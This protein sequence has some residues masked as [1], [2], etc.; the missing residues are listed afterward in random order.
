MKSADKKLML[1]VGR[2]KEMMRPALLL[3]LLLSL[4]AIPAPAQHGNAPS[5]I[6]LS[7]P[8]PLLQSQNDDEEFIKPSRPGVAIPAEIHKAG[9][10]QLEY[11][12]D[13]N[14]RADEFHAEHAA[15]LNL[16]FAVSSRLLFEFDLDTVKSEVDEAK[17]R[18]TGV[19][20]TWLGVQVVALKD[21]EKHPAL[22]F[23][24]YA[25]FPSASQEQGLGTGRFDHRIV[26]LLSKKLGH[27]DVDMNGALL[28]VGRENAG[29]WITGGQGALSFSGEFNNGIGLEGELSGQTKDGVQ[30]KGL[31]ALGSVTYKVSRRFRL[32]TG[33]RFGLNPEAPRVGVFAGLTV[34]VGNFYRR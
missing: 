10:L 32:D 13:G 27:V 1:L 18:S 19:G 30:P 23:A 11:G 3:T 9:V 26:T 31:F 2:G 8:H 14:F 7:P 5:P 28:I 25:K 34:G 22:A 21:T 4:M 20:D 29:G 33:M 6:I 17:K 15:P 16:R 24:Y 12:Y